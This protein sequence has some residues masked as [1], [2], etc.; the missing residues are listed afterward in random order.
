MFVT[1]LQRVC[2]HAGLQDDV[3]PGLRTAGEALTADVR[4]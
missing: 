3:H 4:G 1:L 2:E